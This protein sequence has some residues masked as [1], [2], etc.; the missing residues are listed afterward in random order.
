M[1]QRGGKY[2]LFEHSSTHFFQ[3]LLENWAHVL[4][5]ARSIPCSKNRHKSHT[6]PPCKGIPSLRGDQGPARH[7]AHLGILK[8]YFCQSPSTS[9]PNFSTTYTL[10]P[11]TGPFLG[12]EKEGQRTLFQ[13]PAASLAPNSN[14]AAIPLHFSLPLPPSVNVSLPSKPPWRKLGSVSTPFSAPL[15]H[16]SFTITLLPDWFKFG[17]CQLLKSYLNFDQKVV[18]HARQ[19]A[20]GTTE[21]ICMARE[22]CCLF[23]CIRYSRW[24][25][26]RQT[27]TN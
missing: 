6:G 21:C 26:C 24:L 20:F 13:R 2:W 12:G 27:M 25:P 7:K 5:K 14:A 18:Y 19:R 16:I 9:C 10:Y 11:S 22:T 1:G 4:S 3:A 23:A 17:K 15:G 8:S